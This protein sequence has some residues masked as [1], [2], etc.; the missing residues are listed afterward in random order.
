ML[1]VALTFIYLHFSP[2]V[3]LLFNPFIWIIPVKLNYNNW[4]R[5]Y[6]IKVITGRRERMVSWFWSSF[7]ILNDSPSVTDDSKCSESGLLRE[8]LSVS[9]LHSRCSKVG[10]QLVITVSLCFRFL[11][12]VVKMKPLIGFQTKWFCFFN[13]PDASFQF[14]SHFLFLYYTCNPLASSF[15]LHSKYALSWP[16]FPVST[17]NSTGLSSLTSTPVA[18]C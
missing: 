5:I 11:K 4:Y 1:S 3:Y 8:A 9:P 14:W 2:F 16:V 12:I 17:V 6:Y 7:S 10:C 15:P 13:F 18:A